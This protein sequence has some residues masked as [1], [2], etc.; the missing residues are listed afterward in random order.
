ELQVMKT[1][2]GKAILIIKCD[3]NV[4]SVAPSVYKD[5]E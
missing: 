1:Q 5:L 3:I 2:P 4:D